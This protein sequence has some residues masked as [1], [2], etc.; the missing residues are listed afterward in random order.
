MP[1]ASTAMPPDESGLR[2]LSGVLVLLCLALAVALP[3]AVVW[4]W[5][6]TEPAALAAQAGLPPGAVLANWQLWFGG[7]LAMLPSLLLASGLIS[8]ATCFG[9]FRRGAY[10]TGGNVAALRAFG[11]RVALSGLAGLLVPTLLAL[12]LSV[13][14]SPGQRALV[15][16]LESGP[17]MALVFGGAVWAISAVMARAV[18]IAEDHAQIV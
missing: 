8:A 15:L 6:R 7:L 10:L 11:G 4:T 9:L 2:R 17:V 13:G 12:L 1:A 3:L 16:T 14:Q 5:A 18:A